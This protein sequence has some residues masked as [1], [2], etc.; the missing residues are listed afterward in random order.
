[1]K[2]LMHSPIVPP[3]R[4]GPF[5]IGD[6]IKM[7][8]PFFYR[9]PFDKMK[10]EA[11]AWKQFV[12]KI[13]DSICIS[14]DASKGDIVSIVVENQFKGLFDGKIGIGS[15]VGE[16][17]QIEQN[18]H[19]LDYKIFVGDPEFYV[20]HDF[21]GELEDIEEAFDAKITHIGIELPRWSLRD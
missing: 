16:L 11:W 2:E 4:I 9:L 10:F 19:I 18:L 5:T 12:Y 15:T 20:F 21:E 3:N 17:Y 7:H 14:V 1:M 13:N 8:L 6:P